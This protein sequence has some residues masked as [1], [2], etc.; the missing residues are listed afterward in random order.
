MSETLSAAVGWSTLPD[1]HRA[2]I[3]AAEHALQHFPGAAP[4]LALV[5]GSSWFEQEPLLA[6]VRSAL[7]DVPLAGQSTAG[8]IV[9]EGPISHSCVV[10]LLGAPS[11]ACGLGSAD[12]MKPSPRDGGQRAAHAA[13]TEFKGASRSGLIFFGDGL[14]TCYADVVRGIREA[15][16]TN[17]LV[18]GGM[19]GDDLRFERTYQYCRDRVLSRSVVCAMLGGS[20]KMG[21]G[22]E[23]GFA[24]IS[25]PRRITRSTGH[26]LM[27]LD[28]QPAA[29]VYEEYFGRDLVTQLRA[30]RTPRQTIVFP[31][32]I[33][34]GDSEQWLLRTVAAFGEDGSLACSGEIAEGSWLQLMM[35]S[36]QLALEAARRAAQHAMQ[37]LNRIGC[38]LVFDA[39]ARRQLLGAEHAARE[40]EIIRE[41]V[42][43]S[44]PL[45]GCYTYAQQA[46][47]GPAG[48][49]EQSATQ[50]GSV[51]VVALGT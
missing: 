30:E 46:P 8:E 4:M 41:T 25:R 31:L 23:H 5:F 50:T 10:T 18:A 2:G 20:V 14:L 42:G 45:A 15:I 16:G 34:W 22:I 48:P 49:H 28:G 12:A 1:A 3:H 6:G 35:G 37:T 19:A 9:G 36:R 43:M 17:S 11:M 27:E 39:A 13:L 40:I 38:V 24:P 33:R 21:V 51:L 26:V 47:F 32:G 29:A 44:V 7:G